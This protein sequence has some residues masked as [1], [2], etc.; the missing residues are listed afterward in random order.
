MSFYEFKLMSRGY[1]RER[2]YNDEF[3]M[4]MTRKIVMA[5]YWGFNGDYKRFPKSEIEVFKTSYD[6]MPELSD[7]IPNDVLEQ[8][9]KELQEYNDIVN[10][11]K[12][13]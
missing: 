6:K 9:N 2:K 13:N 4:I 11:I 10:Q 3:F 5:A 8:F 1:H 12:N 7:I